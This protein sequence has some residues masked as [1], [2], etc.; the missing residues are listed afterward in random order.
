VLLAEGEIEWEFSA[1]DRVGDRMLDAEVSG[2]KPSA[3]LDETRQRTYRV[4]RRDR[5]W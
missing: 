3:I 2:L 4:E 1:S 5:E